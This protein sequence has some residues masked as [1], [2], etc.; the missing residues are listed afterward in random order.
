MRGGF[1]D[2]PTPY[3]AYALRWFRD[4]KL[5][6]GQIASLTIE[7]M[8]QRRKSPASTRGVIENVTGVIQFP[9]DN[10]GDAST[11]GITLTGY[12]SVS[13]L[14]DYP[15]S[16]SDFGR[17]VPG[18][19]KTCLSTGSEALGMTWALD[20]SLACADAQVQSSEIPNHDPPKKHGAI[21]KFEPMALNAE[22][23]LCLSAPSPQ[24]PFTDLRDLTRL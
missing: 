20:N 18:A 22:I 10:L 24:G 23:A 8:A 9:P 13:L 11:A 3:D 1:S 6:K 5:N 15:E 21:E 16:V 14:R 2:S 7:A 17:T 12:S 4:A 19:V